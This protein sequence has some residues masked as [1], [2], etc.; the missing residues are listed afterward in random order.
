METIDGDRRLKVL[1]VDDDEAMARSIKKILSACVVTCEVDPLAALARLRAG[2]RY[3]SVLLDQSM[4]AMSGTRFYQELLEFAPEQAAAVSFVTGDSLQG[5]LDKLHL[6]GR[7]VLA[8]PFAIGELRDLVEQQVVA[9]TLELSLAATSREEELRRQIADVELRQAQKLEEL[10]RLSA[11][12]AHEINTPVQFVSDSLHFLR[13]AMSEVMGV[14]EKMREVRRSAANGVPSPES[15][16]AAAAAED[17]ADLDYLFENVP[18]AFDRTLDGLKRIATIV[19]SMKEFAHPDAAE[20]TSVDLNRAIESTLTI[21]RGEYKYV[22]EL[23]TDFGSLA[24][25]V[26]FAGEINQTVLNIVV[27]A[28]HAIADVVKDTG[29]KGR[30]TIRTRQEGDQVLIAIADTGGGIPEAIRE[31]VFEPFFTTKGVGKGTGQGLALA[32]TVVVDK[33]GGELRLESVMGTGTT[34]LIRLPV[35]GRKAPG[36]GAGTAA[37]A[38]GFVSSA[39]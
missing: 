27:N 26:C 2:E 11:G 13:D 1:V 25:L 20:M 39:A 34:F 31:R 5:D 32:R 16:E 4:P 28:A 22:A 8:K 29:R 33:H 37:A 30:I 36:N 6:L 3:D 24:P 38:Q 19:R 9:R 18:K 7:P 14:V 21:A 17:A 12:V 35:H 15:M 10:G 23:E